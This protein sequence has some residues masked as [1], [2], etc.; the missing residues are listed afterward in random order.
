[1]ASLH[2]PPLKPYSA[3]AIRLGTVTLPPGAVWLDARDY[4]E[5]SF[6]TLRPTDTL[7]PDGLR[8]A[9]VRDHGFVDGGGIGKGFGGEVG[10]TVAFRFTIGEALADSM[11]LVRYRLPREQQSAFASTLD[12]GEQRSHIFS[13]SGEDDFALEQIELGTQLAPGEHILRLTA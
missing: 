8:R 4:A 9:E 6:A 10:D 5:L 1:M 13:G 2:F 3:E 12:N 11:L 7:N